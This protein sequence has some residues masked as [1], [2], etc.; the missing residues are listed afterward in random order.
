[1]KAD[2]LIHLCYQL[3]AAK[4]ERSNID[5]T[6]LLFFLHHLLKILPH[7]TD[8]CPMGLHPVSQDDLS[9][10]MTSHYSTI[11]SLNKLKKR[12]ILIC[13]RLITCW[14]D[15]CYIFCARLAIRPASRPHKTS[16]ARF[17]N[18]ADAARSEHGGCRHSS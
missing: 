11:F 14:H 3:R 4:I 5:L 13:P 1:M 16:S 15:S 2:S 10:L 6:R 12:Y 9:G 18:H 7:E 17:K 8:S